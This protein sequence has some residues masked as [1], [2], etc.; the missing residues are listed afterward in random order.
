MLGE[1][2]FNTDFLDEFLFYNNIYYKESN[3][4]MVSLYVLHVYCRA[5]VV[6]EMGLQNF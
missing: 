3:T 2:E 6:Q 4:I 5:S 1:V